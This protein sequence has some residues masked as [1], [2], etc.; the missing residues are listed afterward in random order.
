M[1]WNSLWCGYDP[2]L[3]LWYFFFFPGSFLSRF[4]CTCLILLVLV[5][6]CLPSIKTFIV[7]QHQLEEEEKLAKQQNELLKS[8]YEKYDM[9]DS[10]TADGTVKQVAR[11]YYDVNITDDWRLSLSLPLKWLFWSWEMNGKP[12]LV[13]VCFAAVGRETVEA[14]YKIKDIKIWYCWITTAKDTEPT[15]SESTHTITPIVGFSSHGVS[16]RTY[17]LY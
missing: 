2:S 6:P 7:L 14:N 3:F 17:Y 11:H 4:W 1:S 5:G 13:V 12:V 9:L 8:N 15:T 10:I 16:L